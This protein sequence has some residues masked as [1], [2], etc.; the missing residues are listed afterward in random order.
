MCPDQIGYRM[1]S[2]TSGV[3]WL[4]ITFEVTTCCCIVQNDNNGGLE[5]MNLDRK[6]L[7]LIQWTSGPS[8]IL[9]CRKE[10]FI[11]NQILKFILRHCNGSNIASE[12]FFE[13]I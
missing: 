5:I 4:T 13:E 7:F 6:L 11:R 8:I 10:K 2:S 3:S 9:S 12:R 1:L